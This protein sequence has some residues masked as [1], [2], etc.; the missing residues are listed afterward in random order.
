MKKLLLIGALGVLA[1]GAHATDLTISFDLTG[2]NSVDGLYDPNNPNVYDPDNY[3]VFINLDSYFAHDYSNYVVTDVSWDN[4]VLH[5]VAPGSWCS[6]SVFSLENTDASEYI[7]VAPSSLDASGSDGPLSSGGFI[8]AGPVHALGDDTVYFHLWE[9]FDD[10][11]NAIDN[12]YDSGIVT[13]K[14]HADDPVPEPASI[15]ALGLGVLALARR[16]RK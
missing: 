4:V 9:V 11:P 2:L 15:A 1:A 3:A 14:I 10:A 12:T 13:Y 6:D 8:S 16:R 5:T 7:D